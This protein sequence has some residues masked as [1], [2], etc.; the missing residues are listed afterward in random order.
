MNVTREMLLA[1][2]TELASTQ[3]EFTT[4]DVLRLLTLRHP[5]E[6]I[7]DLYDHRDGINPFRTTHGKIGQEMAKIL[8]LEKLDR[9]ADP[10]IRGDNTENQRWR[11]R[12]S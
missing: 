6:Y 9:V 11:L 5:R 10:N 4:H 7:L 8:G 2:S 1:L 3:E 12:R